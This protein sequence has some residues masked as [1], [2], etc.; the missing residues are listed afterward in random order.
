ME[1]NKTSLFDRISNSIFAKLSVIFI[2]VLL[3]LI[4]LFWVK[5]LIEERKSRQ[6]EVSQE[7]AFKWGNQQVI[8]GPIFAI[9][10]Q[11]AQQVVVN[12]SNKISTKNTY[13]TNYVYLLPKSLQINS[14]VL[15]ESLK[16]GIYQSVVYNAQLDL[17]GSFDAIDFSKLEVS[18]ADLEWKNAK[19]LIGLS[20]LKGLGASPFL[21]INDQKIEFETN[22]SALDP[23]EKNMVAAIDL[24]QSKTT[25]GNFQIKFNLRGSQ[26]INFFPLAKQTTIH[27]KGNWGNPSFNGAI[28]PDDR[29]ITAQTFDATWNIPS[30]SRKLAQQW[31]GDVKRLYEINNNYEINSSSEDNYTVTTN[32]TEATVAV[33]TDNNTASE[34]DMIQIN[35]LDEV[36]NYQKTTR[37]AK[38]GILIIIL[39]FTALFFTEII[40]KQRI[41]F[42]QYMLIGFAMV[43]FYSLLLA[44]SEHLGFNIAYLLAAIATIVLI[45]SFVKTITKDNKSALL[46]SAIL[47]TFY[48]FIYVLM[49]LRDLSLIVGTVGIFII[50]AVLM[51]LSTKINWDQ[52]ER[53]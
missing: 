6:E 29:K 15:P 53:K 24:N 14:L 19:I 11:T 22:M 28:L 43:L 32:Q 47:S 45:A 7:I 36:N 35:F 41:H 5:E 27:A 21:Q 51:R 26:S 2:L 38:Y 49:Q 17:K 8:S 3:L 39:S 42:I 13:V 48:V 34:K 33:A 40:K 52:I 37:V 18:P 4:P 16:R 20:D 25:T 12:E 50:L 44:I 31:T 10:Y 46:F 30:F 23:F 9:P 1:T